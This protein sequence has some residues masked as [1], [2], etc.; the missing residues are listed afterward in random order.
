M[1]VYKASNKRWVKLTANST[2]SDHEGL[3]TPEKSD[4]HGFAKM[5][6]LIFGVSKYP[7]YPKGCFLTSSIL[8]SKDAVI[9]NQVK[10]GKRNS[11][12]KPLCLVGK[13]VSVYCMFLRISLPNETLTMLNVFYLLFRSLHVDVR[14]Y[15]RIE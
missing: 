5:S 14:E 6:K 8:P 11:K 7:N 12:A 4:C 1:F 3:I 9:W 10:T 13:Y 2:C 15:G